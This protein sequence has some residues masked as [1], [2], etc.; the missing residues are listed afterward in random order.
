MAGSH[1]RGFDHARADLFQD[2][3]CAVMSDGEPAARERIVAFWRALGARVVVRDAAAH[4]A[5]VAWVSHL[6][7]LLAFAFATALA[8][9]P[10]SASELR[11]SG[12][13]DFTRLAQSDPEL[14]ADILTSN[15]KALAAP[16]GAV[17]PALQ[18][19]SSVLESDDAEALERILA[20][21]RNALAGGRTG[22]SESVA[23]PSNPPKPPTAER[24]GGA[25]ES[26]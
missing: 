25:R 11:G 4:D 2:A 21:A 19:L 13:R 9:A 5:E 20:A 12:F 17:G 22:A 16:L 26:H 3:P 18:R 24:P 14:W 1:A 10:Q 15:R 8:Q 6:P 23:R 7:H